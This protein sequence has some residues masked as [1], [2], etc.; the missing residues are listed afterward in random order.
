MNGTAMMT[1]R[2]KRM[3]A[4]LCK[5]ALLA[6]ALLLIVAEAGAQTKLER[7]WQFLA[8]SA[9][10]LKVSDVTS[11]AGWRPADRKSVV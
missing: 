6:A 8:D 5:A 3:L 9:G 1:D 11:A 2:L 10:A 4:C 7:D